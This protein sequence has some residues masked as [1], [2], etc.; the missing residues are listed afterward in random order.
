MLQDLISGFV[1][2]SNSSINLLMGN[3][4]EWSDAL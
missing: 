4:P 2:F 1:I 3:V